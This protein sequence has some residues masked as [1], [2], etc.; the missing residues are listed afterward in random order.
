MECNKQGTNTAGTR[1]RG[2]RPADPDRGTLP[3][4][5]F[6]KALGLPYTHSLPG[7]AI[8]HIVYPVD[9]S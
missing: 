6:Q 5:S 4:A 3:I 2:G 9:S 1:S 7:S 8:V